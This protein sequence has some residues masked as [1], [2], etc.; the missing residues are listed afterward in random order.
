MRRTSYLLFLSVVMVCLSCAVKADDSLTVDVSGSF[1]V[2]YEALNNPIF[3]TQMSLRE[4]SN[5][6]LST[7]L[8][9]NTDVTYKNFGATLDIRDSRAFL[10]DNDPTLTSSQ[11]NTLEPVQLFFT[12]KPLNARG[13]ENNANALGHISLIKMGRM[14]LDYGSRRLLAKAIYRNATNSYDG[15]V[16]QGNL[17]NWRV[18]GLYILPVSRFP[19]DIESVDSNTRAFDKSFSE[20]KLFGLYAASNDNAIKLQSYWFKEDDS[21][22][23]ATRNRDLFTFSVDYTANFSN[24]WRANTEIIGQLGSAHETAASNDTLDKDVRAYLMFAYVGKK[25]NHHT[26]LR[27][28]FDFIS[29]DN[30]STDNTISNFDSLYGVRRFDFGPTDVYQGLLRRNLKTA[31]LRSV[32]T[33]TAQHNIMLGYKAYWYQKAPQDVDSFIGHQVEARWRY[34]ILPELRLSLGGAYLFKGDGFARGD[35]SDNSAFLFTGALYTF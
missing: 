2:R 35:Y 15:V 6:R 20:R 13:S 29:G 4:K 10:D 22:S 32:S 28:E 12:Y 25:I 8:I 27:A 17:A 21:E 34:Q 33:P 1:R 30:D 3:P 11:V 16:V 19:N 9:V 14:E 18:D 26:F 24:G 7:R 23:L 31:G 5:Q